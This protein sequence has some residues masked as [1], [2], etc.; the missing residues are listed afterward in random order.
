MFRSNCMFWMK[1]SRSDITFL[2]T[3]QHYSG[4]VNQLHSEITTYI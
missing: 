3:S 2:K 4:N 1:I